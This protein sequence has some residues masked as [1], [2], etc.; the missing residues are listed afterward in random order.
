MF[1]KILEILKEKLRLNLMLSLLIKERY[2]MLKAAR[3]YAQKYPEGTIQYHKLFNDFTLSSLKNENVLLFVVYAPKSLLMYDRFFQLFE[4]LNYKIVV[5]ANSGLSSEFIERFQ[6]KVVLIAE[7][8]N[9]GRDF[10][11]YKEFICKLRRENAQ[12]K[13]LIICNDSIFANLKQDDIRFTDFLIS[14]QNKDFVGAAEYMGVPG[15]HVQSYFLKFS[16]KVLNSTHFIKFW[17]EFL[18]SDDRRLNIHNGEIKL[19]EA[20]LRGGFKPVV[21]LSTDC[22]VNKIVD[23][24]QKLEKFLIEA[25]ANKHL[26]QHLIGG[27]KNLSLAF[28]ARRITPEHKAYFSASLKLEITR[29]IDRFGIIVVCPYF[30]I[31]ELGFPFLKRDLV[32]RQITEWG[33]IREFGKNFDQDLLDEYIDDQRIRRRHWNLPTLKDKLMYNTGMN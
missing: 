31:D 22:V 1:K 26:D 33:L 7:R 10:G 32:Y 14:N 25:S 19:T 11:A 16:Q 9:I 20:I 28:Y 4:K 6:N 18:I 27:L 30:I 24:K 12:P 3:I 5:I 21:F 15:Y 8:Y 23:D 13:N 2:K 17:N 29:L